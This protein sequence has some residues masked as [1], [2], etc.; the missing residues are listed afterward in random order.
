LAAFFKSKIRR[1]AENA[2]LRQQ[3]LRSKSHG[4]IRPNGGDRF[5]FV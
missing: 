3:L 4:R 5:F 1:E 2:A